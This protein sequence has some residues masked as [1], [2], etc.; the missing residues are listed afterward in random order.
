MVCKIAVRHCSKHEMKEG[1]WN[2]IWKQRWQCL[3]GCRKRRFVMT[4]SLIISAR[5][6]W[7]THKCSG[8]D[9]WRNT[10]VWS[11]ELWDFFFIIII[12]VIFEFAIKA[13]LLDLKSPSIFRHI[14]ELRPVNYINL[15]LRHIFSLYKMRDLVSSRSEQLTL[16]SFSC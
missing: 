6:D 4:C 9:T 11:S 8:R 10:M 1:T 7:E 3:A 14:L 16:N 2:S 12:T 5:C 13:D 15:V